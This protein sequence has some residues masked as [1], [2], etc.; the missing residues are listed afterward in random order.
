MGFELPTMT[1]D[2]KRFPWS[3]TVGSHSLNFQLPQVRWVHCPTYSSLPWQLSPL[4]VERQKHRG[5]PFLFRKWSLKKRFFFSPKLTKE[6]NL[7]HKKL[8][9]KH[10]SNLRRLASHYLEACWMVGFQPTKQVGKTAGCWLAKVCQRWWSKRW[11]PNCCND[12]PRQTRKFC[13]P[14]RGLTYLT[15]RESRKI[16]FP[17][18]CRRLDGICDRSQEGFCWISESGFPKVIQCWPFKVIVW[19][20]KQVEIQWPWHSGFWIR[21]QWYQFFAFK[22]GLLHSKDG[23]NV[24][25]KCW[26]HTAAIGCKPSPNHIHTSLRF[27][28]TGEV[29]CWFILV[30]PRPQTWCLIRC[31]WFEGIWS[32][33]Y[34]YIYM[35]WPGN[36]GNCAATSNIKHV[37]FFYHQTSG[38]LKVHEVPG[39]KW[40]CFM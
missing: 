6:N 15:K 8:Q 12:E 18:K 3:P 30:A 1:G 33:I 9:L 2:R 27:R 29:Y 7:S 20:W 23:W 14:S 10:R 28:R 4:R 25:K 19:C 11:C 13:V 31:P 5:L 21:H 16:I 34:I 38:P 35:N 26:M 39:M 36:Y 40:R 22:V 24:V 17:Q 32:H 37:S